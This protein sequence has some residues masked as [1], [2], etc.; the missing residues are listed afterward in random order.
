VRF[1]ERASVVLLDVGSG[2][3]RGVEIGPNVLVCGTRY[4]ENPT[5]LLVYGMRSDAAGREVWWVIWCI[6]SDG[7]AR[8][9]RE[10]KCG[11][12]EVVL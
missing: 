9:L 5:R 12:G 7:V 8:E 6:G 11:S 4:V 1:H 10:W 3:K 2:D